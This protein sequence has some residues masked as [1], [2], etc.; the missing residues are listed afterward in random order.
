ML[1]LRFQICMDSVIQNTYIVA[2]TESC[3]GFTPCVNIMSAPQIAVTIEV[4]G[5]EYLTS[6]LTGHICQN[7][8]GEV[9]VA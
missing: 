6:D 5:D 9:V 3:N 7:S 1:G 8:N 4:T 2:I